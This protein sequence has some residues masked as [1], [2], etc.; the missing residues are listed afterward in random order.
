MRG[1]DVHLTRAQV[2]ERAAKVEAADTYLAESRDLL[3][4][5]KTIRQQNRERAPDEPHR[6]E[7]RVHTQDDLLD[8]EGQHDPQHPE[9]ELEGAIEEVRYG[10]DPKEAA[11]K[12]RTAIGQEADKAADQRQIQRLIGQDNTKST[13]AMKAFIEA[14][15]DLAEDEESAEFMERAIY[16]IQREE[17][18]KVGIDAEKLPRDTKTLAQWHQFQ[19]IHGSPVSDQ[20]SMLGEAKRRLEAFR[21][22]PQRQQ[23]E[24]RKPGAPP[25]VEVSVNRDARRERLPNQP[26]R[27][28]APPP[29][30][31]QEQPAVRDR[32]SVIANM[33][34]S[35]G[36]IVA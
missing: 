3:E 33:R 1:K 15:K 20:E 4:Q 29:T 24:Q 26:T 21:G 13:K 30:R 19:R 22:T 25:R 10:A 7:G 8:P 2:L 23:Q 11:K 16:R 32:S 27:T 14:N 35:R 31:A 9:D 5:A 6:P 17:L 12:L 28:M 36:Q 18:I 34:K